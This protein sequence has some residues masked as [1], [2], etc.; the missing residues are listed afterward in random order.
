[1]VDNFS[2]MWAELPDCLKSETTR[3][4]YISIAEVLDRYENKIL[5]YKNMR[6]LDS[7]IGIK[8]D[9][10]GEILDIKRRY[11]V[12]DEYRKQL[13]I[14]KTALTF[15]PTM[16]NFINLLTGTLG[17]DCVIN[18]GW[19]FGEKAAIEVVTNT[20]DSNLEILYDLDK[21][22]SCGIKVIWRKVGEKH[23]I[24]E[25]IGDHNT[26]GRYDFTIDSELVAR[27]SVRKKYAAVEIV[28]EH[29]NSGV[30]ELQ[31]G[32]TEVTDE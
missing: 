24:Y 26:T 28:G 5:A 12:D 27:E 22:Y 1:M 4:I 32:V 30:E 8:L 13:R 23:R 21:I 6:N 17:Y 14:S 20:I 16:N 10:I 19:T 25:K 15:I 3:K 9:L 11:R 18:E 2:Y 29:N 31:Q 7:A